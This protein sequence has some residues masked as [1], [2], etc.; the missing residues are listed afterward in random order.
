MHITAAVSR[1]ISEINRIIGRKSL[2]SIACIGVLVDCHISYGNTRIVWLPK[3]GAK[4]LISLAILR[5]YRRVMD[6]RTDRRT[7]CDS[8]A[9]SMRSI[10][11]YKKQDRGCFD[12]R[13]TDIS[14]VITV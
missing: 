10:A 6:K 5:E 8:M 1:I 7:S 3:N 2:F 9:R 12:C 4:S 14:S 11:R 13:K